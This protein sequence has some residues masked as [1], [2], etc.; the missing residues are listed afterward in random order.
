LP[1]SCLSTPTHFVLLHFLFYP[2]PA[3]PPPPSF[4][5]RRSSD[6]DLATLIRIHTLESHDLP[7]SPHSGAAQMKIEETENQT[8]RTTTRRAASS[9]SACPARRTHHTSAS[10]AARAPASPR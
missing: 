7:L 3:L 9:R 2:H 6:L 4:P 8:I 1:L 5:T 10:P